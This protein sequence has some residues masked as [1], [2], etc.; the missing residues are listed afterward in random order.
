[1]STYL[2]DTHILLWVLNEDPRLSEK[3]RE[4]FL[5]GKDIVVSAV[6]ILEIAIKKS[7]GKVVVRLDIV[8]LLRD[9]GVPIL[10]VNGRHAAR[11]EH[12]PLYHRDPFDRVLVAQAQIEGLQVVTEDANIRQ[13]DI[14]LA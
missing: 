8:E 14:L 11:V 7:L 3:H 4:I 13:Y 10:A 2:I 1:V 6:S 9:R 5:S 12:F